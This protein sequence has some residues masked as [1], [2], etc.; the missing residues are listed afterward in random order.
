[1]GVLI[2]AL[3]DKLIDTRIHAAAAIRNMA[4]FGD[5]RMYV[6]PHLYDFISSLPSTNCSISRQ[7]VRLL[8][9]SYSL[10]WKYFLLY[11]YPQ[12]VLF[13]HALC[14]FGANRYMADPNLGLIQV[15]SVMLTEETGELLLIITG[16]LKNLS[17]LKAMRKTLG[18][19]RL[20]LVN[21]LTNLLTGSC[22]QSTMDNSLS[23]LRNLS[24]SVE[25]LN[26]MC[27]NE[28]GLPQALVWVL[29][30]ADKGNWSKVCI[31]TSHS[32]SQTISY[33]TPQMTDP[34]HD[35]THDLTCNP[36]HTRMLS[37]MWN[38][39]EFDSEKKQ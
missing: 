1:M 17:T 31:S 25:N 7:L 9:S 35:L 13:I 34:T 38:N 10:F 8:H 27:S 37:G 20:G 4:S 15:L 3:K 6:K 29:Y 23:I 21:A 19:S 30:N 32:T 16:V 22:D 33:T 2:E 12:S 14:Y 11:L 26:Y 39:Q 18:S 36:T 28:L 24:K 5:N